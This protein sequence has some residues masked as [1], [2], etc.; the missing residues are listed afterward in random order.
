MIADNR[1]YCTSKLT[2]YRITKKKTLYF[3]CNNESRGG[4]TFRLSPLAELIPQK[5]LL[6]LGGTAV[7]YC[8]K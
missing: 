6:N 4:R 2:F 8:F 3:P 5:S 7:D 1:Q